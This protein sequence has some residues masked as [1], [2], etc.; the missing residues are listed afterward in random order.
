MESNNNESA[1][2]GGG[3]PGLF[4]F[5]SDD[6]SVGSHNDGLLASK[7][8]QFGS[9]SVHSLNLDSIEDTPKPEFVGRT[10]LAGGSRV[11]NLVDET[12]GM[13]GPMYSFLAILLA[14][15][16]ATAMYPTVLPISQQ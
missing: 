10:Q 13:D 7:E 6:N 16:D 9:I 11:V 2:L 4:K 3:G 15:H 14:P 1:N 5:P 8:S 12:I